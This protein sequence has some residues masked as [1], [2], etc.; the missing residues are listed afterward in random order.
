MQGDVN[1]LFLL[2]SAYITLLPKSPDALEIKDFRPISL[3]HSFAKIVSK[4]L[5]NILAG[6]LPSLVSN[7]Q[8]AFIK[9]RCIHDN[10]IIVHQTAMA[11]HRQEPMILLK[12][13][14]TKAFD[15]MSCLSCLK[16]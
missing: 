2:N 8:S 15:S 1:R 11:L 3:I 4:L 13:D 14:I 6:K 10:F 5:A 9:G 7:S 16:Y 12:L